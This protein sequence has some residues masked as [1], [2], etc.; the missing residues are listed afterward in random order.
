MSYIISY[1]VIYHINKKIHLMNSSSDK[2][3]SY[4]LPVTLQIP[5]FTCVSKFSRFFVI[6]KVPTGFGAHRSP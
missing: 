6:C 3:A 2:Q 5:P 4:N 1:H